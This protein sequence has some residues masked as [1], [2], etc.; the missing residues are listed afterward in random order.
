MVVIAHTV[1]LVCLWCARSIG[2]SRCDVPIEYRI[3]EV[4]SLVDFEKQVCGK[5]G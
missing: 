2:D 1:V 3:C 4:I 5:V